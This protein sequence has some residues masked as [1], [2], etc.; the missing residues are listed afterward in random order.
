MFPIDQKL[1]A[2]INADRQRNAE[3]YRRL[4]DLKNAG[5]GPKP[6]Q[7]LSDRFGWALKRGVNGTAK[8]A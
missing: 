3:H 2:S 4:Q 1:V 6:R 8:Q 5:R 7:T